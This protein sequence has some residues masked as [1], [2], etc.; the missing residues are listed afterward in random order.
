MKWYK[1]SKVT[2]SYAYRKYTVIM[3][4]PILSIATSSQESSPAFRVDCVLLAQELEFLNKS[5]EMSEKFV[6]STVHVVDPPVRALACNRLPW[7]ELPLGFTDRKFSA[8]ERDATDLIVVTDSEGTMSWKTALNVIARAFES[9]AKI[10]GLRKFIL[11]GKRLPDEA[12]VDLDAYRR[13]LVAASRRPNG[14]YAKRALDVGISCA[15]CIFLA[16][17]MLCV[18]AAVRLDSE[19]PALF[20]QERLGRRRVSFRCIKFRTMR[21]NAERGSGPVRSHVNDPRITRVGRFLRRSRL[22]ELPQLLNVLKGDMS[23]VGPRPIRKCFADELAARM[24]LYDVR[25]LEKPGITGWAQIKFRYATSAEEEI[26]KLRFDFFYVQH[27]SFW[28]DLRILFETISVVL[29]MRGI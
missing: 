21:H 25:F 29:R 9:D 23:L 26:E 11:S 24:P 1:L 6:I 5:M 4:K 7:R 15:L 10:C 27:R 18:A 16:P 12:D 28:L 2:V 19:G 14:R 20:V 3:R 22:D 17:L 13:V 8:A